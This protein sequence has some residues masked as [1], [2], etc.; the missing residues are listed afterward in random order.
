MDCCFTHG[1]GQNPHL[2][3]KEKEAATFPFFFQVN[4][5]SKSLG[6]RLPSFFLPEVDDTQGGAIQSLVRGLAVSF[7]REP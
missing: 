7:R 5:M 4:S 3:L 1:F 6:A 2:V